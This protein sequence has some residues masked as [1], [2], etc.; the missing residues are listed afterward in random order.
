[1]PPPQVMPEGAAAFAAIVPGD[2]VGISSAR[3][4]PRTAQWRLSGE[5]T[6]PIYL[7]PGL[8]R[9][10]RVGPSLGF[11]VCEGDAGEGIAL[12]GGRR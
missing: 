4:D 10:I 8:A 3:P 2:L 9:P 5:L 1:M 12:T 11:A 6:E 7:S